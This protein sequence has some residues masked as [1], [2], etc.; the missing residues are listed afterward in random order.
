MQ[1][2]APSLNLHKEMSWFWAFEKN[3][4]FYWVIVTELLER[5]F[6]YLFHRRSGPNVVRT[7]F[8]NFLFFCFFEM[9]FFFLKQKFNVDWGFI[10]LFILF[11][12]NEHKEILWTTSFLQSWR[13]K[14]NSIPLARKD[15]KSLKTCNQICFFIL[16]NFKL[17]LQRQSKKEM[18]GIHICWEQAREEKILS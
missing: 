2:D 1:K 18:F 4:F 11:I 8:W 16:K 6:T 3:V 14:V 12:L 7:K 15:L 13:L 9:I 5:M 17:S 10:Y